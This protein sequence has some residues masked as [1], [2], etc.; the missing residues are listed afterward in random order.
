MELEPF[1]F[2]SVQFDYMNG[3]R[4]GIDTFA[5]VEYIGYPETGEEEMI[6]LRPFETIDEI[7]KK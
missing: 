5:F 3:K 1:S 4:M 6:A 7:L 2:G